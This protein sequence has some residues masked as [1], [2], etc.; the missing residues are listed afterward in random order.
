MSAVTTNWTRPA[1]TKRRIREAGDV[2]RNSEAPSDERAQAIAVANNWRSSH[3][4]PL[5]T[6]QVSL[7]SKATSVDEHA[8]VAQRVKRLPSIIGKLQR[9]ESMGLDRMQDLGGCRAVVRD[10]GAAYTVRQKFLDSAHKHVRKGEK[11][12][13]LEPATSGYRGLHMIYQYRSDRMETWNGLRIEVQIRTALQ[14][15]WATAVETVGLF[16]AQALK[17]SQGEDE[18]LDFFRTMS[19]QIALL[20][21]AAPVPGTPDSAAELRDRLREHNQSLDVLRRLDTYAQT[22]EF[23]EKRLK[24]ARF[25]LLTLNVKEQEV[26]ATG[27]RSQEEATNAYDLVEAYSGDNTDVVLVSVNSI[28]GLRNAYPNYFLDTERF[29]GLLRDALEK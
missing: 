25:I 17:S 20:E 2:L 4:F 27:Y 1:H 12:Y 8:I 11:D 7:R 29:A 14:H 23:T 24:N 16:T 6:F 13:I 28:A 10:L 22:L 5:N 26:T 3:A 15:A 21:D 19:T 9:F 18:W